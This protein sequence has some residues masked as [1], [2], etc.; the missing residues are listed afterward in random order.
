[1][2]ALMRPSASR[3]TSAPLTQ[4]TCSAGEVYNMLI[5]LTTGRNN[6]YI[7]FWEL[8]TFISFLLYIHFSH[9]VQATFSK[10]CPHCYVS[11][12]QLECE[13]KK[14]HISPLF[15]AIFAIKRAVFLYCKVTKVSLQIRKKLFICGDS[16]VADYYYSL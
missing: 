5:N 15:Y 10:D 1:M 13:V 12:Q 14:L 16:A 6:T 7:I 11:I 8:E 4:V 9:V 2:T 3:Q